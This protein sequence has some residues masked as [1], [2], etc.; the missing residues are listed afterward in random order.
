MSKFFESEVG[1][2]S[3]SVTINDGLSNSTP[4]AISGENVAAG[5]QIGYDI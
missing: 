4:A 2:L 3:I 5:R 1:L